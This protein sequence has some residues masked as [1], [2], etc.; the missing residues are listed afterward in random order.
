[1]EEEEAIQTDRSCRALNVR[2]KEFGPPPERNGEP[3]KG[4]QQ[5]CSAGACLALGFS[6]ISW[7]WREAEVDGGW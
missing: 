5:E 7:V 4:V 6:S 1:M 3:L 2:V